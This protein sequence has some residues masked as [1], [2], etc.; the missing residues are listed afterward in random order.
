MKKS[1]DKFIYVR[2]VFDYEC[3]YNAKSSR[4][5]SYPPIV[6]KL[7]LAIYLR[8]GV[9]L[10]LTGCLVGIVFVCVPT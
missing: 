9:L 3:K 8:L 5:N 4:D 2:E 6:P 10:A 7:F 1:L